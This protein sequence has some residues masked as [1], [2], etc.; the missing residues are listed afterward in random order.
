GSSLHGVARRQR[1]DPLARRRRGTTPSARQLSRL[2]LFRRHARRLDPGGLAGD[3]A[4]SS[5]AGGRGG[6][7][8]DGSNG[9]D[10]PSAGGGRRPFADPSDGIGGGLPLLHSG[11]GDLLM[12]D[13]AENGGPPG[14]RV[15]LVSGLRRLAAK[16]PRSE[17]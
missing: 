10:A 6:G 11:V 7:R 2:P 12:P 13:L 1:R 9:P 8:S 16:R 4:R 17:E 14:A 5:G 3:G 15:S